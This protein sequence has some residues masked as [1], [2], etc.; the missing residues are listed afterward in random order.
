MSV[1]YKHRALVAVLGASALALLAGCSGSA[2]GDSTSSG[3]SGEKLTIAASF[4][5]L[6]FVTQRIAGDRATVSSLTP[7]GTEPHDLEL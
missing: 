4:Y 1:M 3:T 5:P 6:Q 2:S 7:P